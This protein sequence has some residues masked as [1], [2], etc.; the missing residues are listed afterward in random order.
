MLQQML[1]QAATGKIVPKAVIVPHAGY[2]YS[3]QVAANVYAQL[4][5]AS[6]KINKVVL[7]GPAHCVPFHGIAGTDAD[8][9]A[10]PLGSIP[11]DK[12]LMEKAFTLEGVKA[13]AAAHAQEHS[14]EVQLPFLQSV[15]GDFTLA[16]FVIG[17]ASQSLTAELLETLWGGDDTLIVIS[18]DLS[19]FHNYDTAC[20]CDLQTAE[21]IEHFAGELIG[22]HDACGYAGIRG[23]LQVAK[24]KNMSIERIAL[25]NSGDTAGDK[26]RVVGYAS[27]AL[28]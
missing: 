19:H 5:N 3:G 8:Y 17:D 14:L 6:D 15:L 13:F 10:T 20:K 2:I 26:N 11:I 22:P 1:Q 12:S 28:H 7:I 16:P 21:H 24:D 4:K 23:L 27:Y 18:S 25:C 9:F